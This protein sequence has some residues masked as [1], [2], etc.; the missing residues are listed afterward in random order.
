MAADIRIT[1]EQLKDRMDHGESFTML[2]V[3][4]PAAWEE[5]RTIARGAIRI[6]MDAVDDRLGE[7]PRD[8]PIV[9]YCT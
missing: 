7:V 5:A 3:R 1:V 2:D 9:A 6:S 8:K 4:N